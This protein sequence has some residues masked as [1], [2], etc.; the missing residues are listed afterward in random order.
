[1]FETRVLIEGQLVLMQ[2][3]QSRFLYARYKHP[4][5]RE[6]REKSTG[7]NDPEQAEEF[8]RTFHAEMMFKAKHGVP[9]GDH[10]MD[11]L[12]DLYLKELEREY[13][14]GRTISHSNFE[15]KVRITNKFVRPYFTGKP[16]H[17]V[18]REMLHDYANWRRSYWLNQPKGAKIEYMRSNGTVLSR[19]IGQRE[20][21]SYAHMRDE[22]AILNSMFRIAMTK[23]WAN[24]RDLPAVNFTSDVIPK[25]RTKSKV[26][27]LAFFDPYEYQKIKEMMEPWSERPL[28][29][30]YRRVAAYYYVMLCFT[31]GVRPGTAMD[32]VRWKD[33]QAV[34]SSTG[35]NHEKT[36]VINGFELVK[37]LK[38]DAL[39]D[40]RLD[41]LV[42][43]S[44]VGSYKSIGM[45][46]A[47][48]FLND[49][50]VRW[51]LMASEL[52]ENQSRRAKSERGDIPKRWN[53]DDPIF[54]LPN[55]YK[56]NGVAV[57]RY[58]AQFLDEVG[59]TY[60]PDTQDKRS[61]YSTRHSFITYLQSTG[62]PDSMIAEFTGTSLEMIRK[63]YSH[64]RATAVGFMFEDYSSRRFR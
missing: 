43:Y 27:P 64:Q 4:K 30:R 53:D 20:L 8:A 22:R 1:M 56:L 51:L 54:L 19:P 49:Y 31:T 25:G 21:D 11:K 15:L 18:N 62:I 12:I 35:E 14:Q 16:L 40:T 52:R 63:H 34:D 33:I 44:K 50:Q 3:R 55:G 23:G 46:E 58:F 41:I 45:N 7:T 47:F 60:Q 57:S 24:E 13:R 10:S 32:S 61:L 48:G 39:A 2:R 37:L 9:L 42:P 17:S 29:F 26:K 59:M 6:W 28:K 36:K 5:L 38:G